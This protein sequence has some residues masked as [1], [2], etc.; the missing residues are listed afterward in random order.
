MNDDKTYF[1]ST[2][3][4]NCLQKETKHL[5]KKPKKTLA[6]TSKQSVQRKVRV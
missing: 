1:Y 6:R 5:K 4:A 3:V 2:A